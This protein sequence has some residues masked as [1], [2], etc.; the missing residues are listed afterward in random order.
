VSKEDVEQCSSGLGR[1]FV[2]GEKAAQKTLFWWR[3]ENK[4]LEGSGRVEFTAE[5]AEDAFMLGI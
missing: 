4:V 2:C 3:F 5:D 1:D